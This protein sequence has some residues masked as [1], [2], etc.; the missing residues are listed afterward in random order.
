MA[1]NA[2]EKCVYFKQ[3]YSTFLVLSESHGKK[4]ADFWRFY[5]SRAKEEEH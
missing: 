1:I 4:H 3:E 2:D 5:R